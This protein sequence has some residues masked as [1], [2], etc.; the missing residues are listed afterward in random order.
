M[1]DPNPLYRL[2]SARNRVPP[3]NL[4]R[5]TRLIL[6]GLM[7]L[8]SF[9]RATEIDTLRQ[10]IQADFTAKTDVSEAEDFLAGLRADGS[11]ED[12]SYGNTGRSRWLPILHL[13]RVR[14]MAAAYYRPG[15]ALEGDA[16][17]L[18]GIQR[19]IAFWVNRDPDSTNWWHLQVNTNQQLGAILVMCKDDLDAA[20]LATGISGFK[21]VESKW[22][23]QNR[24]YTSF[25]GVYKAILEDDAATLASQFTRIRGEA[26]YKVGLGRTGVTNN[27]DK[28]GIRRDFSFYQHGP[29]LY[30]GFYGAHFVTDMGFWMA[31]SEGLSFGFT[32][33]EKTV[34][35]DY[36]LEGQRWF[37][38]AGVLDPN[39]VDR[40]ISHDNY[41]YV[42]LRY[43]DPIVYGLEY[44]RGLTL[45]RGE[46]IEAFYQHMTAGAPSPIRGNRSFWK[47][48]VMVQAGEGFQV[49]TKLWS[50]HNEGTEF[51]NGDNIQGGFLPLGGTFLLMDGTEYLEIFP[52]WDWGRIPGTT[53][54]HRDP[55]PQPPFLGELGSQKFAG[56]VSN[57]REGALAYDHDHDQVRAKKS[58]FYFDDVL[59]QLGAGITGGNGS[60]TVNSTLNQSYLRGDVTV[61]AGGVE[62]SAPTGDSAPADPE[63]VFHD[64]V[65]YIFPDGGP[66]TIG[67]KTQSGSWFEIND[68]LSSEVLS[69]EVFTLGFDHGTAPVDDRY[70]AVIVPAV[71]RAAFDAFRAED[72]I[73]I[74]SN[75]PEIQAARH[76]TRQL[77]QITFHAAGTL[78][79]P[80]GLEIT[81]N[82]PCLVM[83]D[84]AESPAHVTVADPTQE[85]VSIQM[86]VTV[87]GEAQ[88]EL[89]FALPAGD[90][91]GRSTDVISDPA[92][93]PLNAT[94]SGWSHQTSSGLASY[95][96]DR[97]TDDD[98]R[99]WASD[100]GYPQ[101]VEIDLGENRSVGGVEV[102]TY[103]NRAYR[104]TVESKSQGGEYGMIVD[105]S[106][107]ADPGPIRDDFDPLTARFLRITVSGATGYS[108]SWISLNELFVFGGPVPDAYQ[109]WRDSIDWGDI[110]E[111]QR[112]PDDDPD[113]DGYTNDQERLFNGDPT[114]K[115]GNLLPYQIEITPGEETLITQ[116]YT[117]GVP[118]AVYRLKHS[119]EVD[120][121]WSGEGVGAESYDEIR[122]AYYQ[123][124]QLPEATRRYFW[125]LEVELP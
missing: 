40:K 7:M 15:H 86:N 65:G 120:G 44:L 51:L 62:F 78:E 109:Q 79:T 8:A 13:R 39:S 32:P 83:V 47:T 125:F 94:V 124:F 21:D 23:A 80:H 48:D 95:L 26:A 70:A 117:K 49:S 99:R 92:E 104:Y 35:Q 96:V 37:N 69:K 27:S 57:G 64:N 71:S 33:I 111:D 29:M 38:R 50:Y 102:H 16:A 9:A 3:I 100:Q 75:T 17:T 72:P 73:G 66:V 89:L 34:I 119:T 20:T 106:A 88:R 41:D 25:R 67:R 84:E 52:V 110:P 22:S 59:V 56:G 93:V 122:T 30:N 76:R 77:T 42:T 91:A 101:W 2:D 108:G 36:V 45:P 97:I 28:E 103:S 113:A 55:G 90:D 81:V 68:S 114:Q 118:E 63:W 31:M 87:P 115:D 107:N 121:D 6:W 46:E 98:D 58:W 112:G 105:R 54:L 1:T 60:L 53:T 19:G 61:A 11:W 10:R 82:E 14:A 116:W 24:I 4:V 85:L 5:V 18:D 12:I 74:L 123:T 43:H